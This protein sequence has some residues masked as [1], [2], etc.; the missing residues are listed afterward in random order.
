[1]RSGQETRKKTRHRE[2]LNEI[3]QHSKDFHEFHKKR[4]TQTKRKAIIFK[5]FLE[6]RAKKETKDKIME[7]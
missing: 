1:M 4:S 2:F 3:L 6:H 7:D 5:N